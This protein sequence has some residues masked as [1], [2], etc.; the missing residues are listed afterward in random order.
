MKQRTFSTEL[1]FVLGH[2]LLAFSSTCM[3]KA[4]F[5]LSM[6]VAPAYLLHLKIGI[7]FGTAEYCMQ[8]ALLLLMLLILRRFKLTYLL[9]FFTAVVYGVVLD[10]FMIIVDLPDLS[11]PARIALFMVGLLSG[12][13]GLS[14]L[15]KSYLTPLVYE[16]FVRETSRKFCVPLG[17]F[18]SYFDLTLC[19][20]GIAL[21]FAFFG[22]GHF[23]GITIGTVIC[24]LVNGRLVGLYSKALDKKFIF[25][26]SRPWREHFA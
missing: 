14:L 17:R 15:F 26:D 2:L 7:S 4:N 19:A 9:S 18:K 8:A 21:S 11:M 16:L 10:T 3:A 13:A 23:E 25:K 5:G 12:P 22:F 20:F 24:A 1:G 6:V